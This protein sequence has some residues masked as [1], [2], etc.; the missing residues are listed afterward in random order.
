[1]SS[2]FVRQPN[3][4]LALLIK[5]KFEEAAAERVKAQQPKAG[6]NVLQKQATATSRQPNNQDL[7]AP[8]GRA[9]TS[10]ESAAKVVGI[11]GRT[12]EY[13]TAPPD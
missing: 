6:Q 4:L 5:P 11:S 8:L 2:S 7:T 3:S 1:M 9:P 10:A 13:R 12:V